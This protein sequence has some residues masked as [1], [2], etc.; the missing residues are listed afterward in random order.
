MEVTGIEVSC[1]YYLVPVSPQ[2]FCQL[3]SDL[4]SFFCRDLAR[5][6]SE[7]LV[8]VIG[9]S[10]AF[11]VPASFDSH[12]IFY[13]CI[14]I[15]VQTG[16]VHHLVSLVF[17]AGIFEHGTE[18]THSSGITLRPLSSFLRI[19]DILDDGIHAF[20][21]RPYGCYCQFGSPDFLIVR[22]RR[23]FKNSSG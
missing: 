1:H 19:L 14:W 22:P 12:E 5:A 20:L 23:V 13:R 6:F 10:A 21:D 7:R 9:K 3:Y 4:V 17:I 8:T 11:L 2:F 18:R 16:D 15:A